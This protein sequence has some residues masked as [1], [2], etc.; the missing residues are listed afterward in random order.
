MNP[1][2][3]LSLSVEMG[4][5]TNTAL[6]SIRRSGTVPHLRLSELCALLSPRHR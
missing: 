5:N 3:F 1:T 2:R 4:K 6:P